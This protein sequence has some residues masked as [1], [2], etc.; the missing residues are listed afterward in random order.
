MFKKAIIVVSG[1]LILSSCASKVHRGVVAMKMDESTAH[2]GIKDNEVKVGDHVELYGNKCTFNRV[3][4]D[5]SCVR[6]SKGHGIITQILNAD[7][8]TVKFDSGVVFQEGDT[9]EK[10]SH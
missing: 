4:Q 6:V 1:A 8:S 10:H 7:Y 5:Q 9:I 2:V 3:A